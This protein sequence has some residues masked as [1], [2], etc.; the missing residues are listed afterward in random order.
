M[1]CYRAGL[2]QYPDIWLVNFDTAAGEDGKCDILQ[3]AIGYNR[4]HIVVSRFPF[5]IESI[6]LWCV[7]SDVAVDK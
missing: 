1:V 3:A 4:L 2:P 6:T 5:T 7:G